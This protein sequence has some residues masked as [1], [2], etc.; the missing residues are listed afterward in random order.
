MSSSRLARTFPAILALLLAACGGGSTDSGNDNDNDNGSTSY[1]CSGSGS[2]SVSGKVE[3]DFVPARANGNGARLAYE[4]TE[5]RPIR[6]AQIQARCP[7]GSATYASAR[8]NDAGEYS[9]SVPENVDVVIRVR[10]SMQRSGAPGWNVRVVDNTRN[11]AVWT[12]QGPEFESGTGSV[13]A[14]LRAASGWNGTS[15]AGTRAAGPFAILDSVYL[16][17]QKVMDAEPAASFPELRLNW[18]PGNTASC[19]ADFSRYPFNDGCIGTSFF[20]N[21]EGFMDGL[22]GR[23]IFVLGAANEDTDEYDRHVIIHEWGHYYEDT[24]SRSDSIGGRHGGNDKLDIRVAFGE[25]WGNAWSAIATN[26]PIY[27]DTMG[28][29]QAS[30]FSLNIENDTT[31]NPGWWNESSVQSILYN[32][33]ADTI[34][35][36]GALGFAPMHDVLTGAQRTTEAMTS[37]FPFIHYLK[38]HADAN[39]ASIET[40]LG[41]HDI[42]SI[43]DV[44]GD[45]RTA[46]DDGGEFEFSN[47]QDYVTPVH[48][49]LSSVTSGATHSACTTKRLAGGSGSNYTS[50]NRLGARRFIRFDV[51]TGGSWRIT[52]DGSNSDRDSDPDFFVFL[53]GEPLYRAWDD[54]S[55]A[56]GDGTRRERQTVD[57]A[58][59]ETYVLEVMD[60]LNIDDDSSTGGDVCLDV[61]FEQQ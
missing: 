36:P 9:L 27:V 50:Y 39:A 25:G 45:G 24:F 18:S 26:D 1:V 29:G 4:A 56:T 59:G 48:A 61:T 55:E 19:S 12:V 13:E 14:N 44:W 54:S 31:M 11:Q 34:L 20:V 16:A 53:R 32:L 21:L 58:Q 47:S 38:Q 37:I 6:Q 28:S 60:W 49:E 5:R 10:A 33:Y 8:S 51:A 57:L 40:L 41:A 30:G 35:H 7:D 52:V 15:Y 23:D 43:N 2:V 22:S 46:M 17:M 42:S 3:Y